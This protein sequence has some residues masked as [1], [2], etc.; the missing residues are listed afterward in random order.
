ML[1]A[2]TPPEIQK[3]LE[4]LP[5]WSTKEVCIWKEFRFKTYMDGIRFV[6]AVA[7]EAEALDHHPDLLV[8]FADVTVFLST[9][10]VNGITYRDFDLAARAEK[11]YLPFIEA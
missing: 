2:M 1:H 3:S 7:L 5:G 8:R 4:P 11:A 6:E 9:H 10:S